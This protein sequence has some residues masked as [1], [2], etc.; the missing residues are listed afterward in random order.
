MLADDTPRRDR[1]D[2]FAA[3]LL[4]GFSIL[5]G[6][7]QALVKIVNTGFEPLFQ[8]GLRSACA[9]VVVLLFALSRRIP[10]TLRDG[11]LPWGI[12]AGVFFAL[13]FGLVFVAL[14]LTTVS[15]VSLFFYTMPL[16]TAIGAHFLVPG[17]RLNAVRVL[18]LVVAMA[19][20]ALA[21]VDDAGGADWRGDALAVGG[22]IAW[23]GIAFV[24]RLSPL[25]RAPSEQVLLYQLLVSAVL[26]LALA[27]L[28]GDSIREVTPFVLGV[29]A[30]QVVAVASLGFLMWLWV[31]RVYPVTNMAAYSLLAPVFGVFFGWLVFD[32]PLTPSFLLALVLVSA[33]I[34]LINR[35]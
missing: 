5:L 6:L 19:G 26:L 1:V 10:M 3:S 27:P 29:F 24:A 16:F 20:V 8:G 11:S 33:G 13:E 32:D 18:G 2:A 15:R 25:A 22:A 12:L 23:A 7:N 28:M 30:F 34:L 21:L 17:E 31:L 9:F 4:I 14:D 35:R